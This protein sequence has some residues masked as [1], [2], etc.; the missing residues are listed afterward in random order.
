[1]INAGEKNNEDRFKIMRKE[2]VDTQ[3]KGRGVR[4]PRVLNAME[5]IPREDFVPKDVKDFSY[6]DL[7]CL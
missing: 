3:I 5:T 2:M 1:M 4:D 7:C 6:M